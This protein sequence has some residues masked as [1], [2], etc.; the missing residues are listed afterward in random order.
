MIYNQDL[1]D[2]IAELPITQ[3]NGT[4]FRVTGKSGNP[5]HASTSGGRWAPVSTG[6]FSVPVLYTSVTRDGAI[7]EVVSYLTQ[8]SPLPS[9]RLFVHQI[10]VST[11]K[12]MTV[13][14]DELAKLG[15]TSSA[16]AQRNYA[17]TQELGAIL[18][19]LEFDALISPS[20]R[21]DCQNL[22][23]FGNNHSIDNDLEI[24]ETEEFD[25]RQW[26]SDHNAV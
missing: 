7:A 16:Y 11:Q 21:W 20:V 19:F 23:I 2:R 12:V 5:L 10:H 9:K 14:I 25:W 8:L 15:I 17:G 22:T 3:F 6:E 4:V 18:N 26:A 24:L 13:T 1:I